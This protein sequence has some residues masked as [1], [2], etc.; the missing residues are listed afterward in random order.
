LQSKFT[1]TS[2]GNPTGANIVL[3]LATAMVYGSLKDQGN[4]PLPGVG[5]AAND[6]T[7]SGSTTTDSGG[8]YFI[9]VAA[10]ANMWFVGVDNQSP[11]LA[12]YIPPQ[13]QS[14]TPGL[15]SATLI[16]FVAP[17]VT[18]HAR[19][20]VLDESS[21]PIGNVNLFAN[22][23]NGTFTANAT[24]DSGGNF[25][26]GLFGGV[27][28]VSINSN[29]LSSLGLVPVAF[30]LT[31]TDGVDQNGLVFRVHHSTGTISG[32]V[33][34]TS[35]NPLTFQ[36][37]YGYATIGGVN[38][39]TGAQTDNS[40]HYSFPV[41]DGTWTV[42]LSQPGFTDQ[43]PIV[44]APTHSAVVNFVQSVITQQPQSQTVTAGQGANF[45]ITTNTPGSNTVQWQL[46]PA[47]SSTWGD[48]VNGA[49]YSGVT[50]N[51]LSVANV[52]IGMSGDRF[53]CNVNYSFGSTTSNAAT[54]TVITQFQAWQMANFT[55][56]QLSDP[57]IS[58]SLATPAGDG[59]S[60]LMKYAL[61]LLPFT[62]CSASLPR[63]T[64]IGSTLTMTFQASRS[65]VTYTVQVS[66]SLQSWT[67]SGVNIQTAGQQ[68]TAT[69]D[70]TG[71]PQSFM[72]LMVTQP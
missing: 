52:T 54:L 58:G 10:N 45:N 70:T 28:N 33:L 37:V 64:R 11:A 7:Y 36:S 2:S 5:I 3:P 8:N 56:A 72:R 50:T 29:D 65:D 14:F 51:S 69:Y 6:P 67:S 62:N 41:I 27:W 60:N 40:G 17:A 13:G 22:T 19:G 12:G 43:F 24:A 63:P 31:M 21:N 55:P 53:R 25:D 71:Q 49:P 68:V 46:L 26:F 47:G 48:L 59:V 9:G 23:N 15:G 44:G 16:N 34:D 4:H 61:N 32:S 1:S 66:S 35:N 30:S 57:N 18:A 20:H 42:G 38:Y 39:S